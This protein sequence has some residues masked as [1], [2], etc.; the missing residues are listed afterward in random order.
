MPCHKALQAHQPQA[1]ALQ[2]LTRSQKH[3]LSAKARS[4]SVNRNPQ[5][6]LQ[7]HSRTRQHAAQQMDPEV[8]V[9]SL[10]F[11]A[12]QPASL[13]NSEGALSKHFIGSALVRG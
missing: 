11:E 6:R 3:C 2:T 5:R 12:A 8:E 10:L 7:P 13:A 9:D 4:Q 1:A